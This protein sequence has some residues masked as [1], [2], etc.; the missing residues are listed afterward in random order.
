[1]I[2]LFA[3]G[4]VQSQLREKA[5]LAEQSREE[6]EATRRKVTQDTRAAFLNVSNGAA[7]VKAREETLKSVKS[8]LEATRLGREVG[9]RTSLDIL[10]AERAYQDARRNL[11]QAR[12]DY[13]KARLRLAAQVGE[14]NPEVLADINRLLQGKRS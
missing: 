1:M 11:A 7:Q 12:Y 8:Q 3:G 5:A 14:L 4:G 10:N 13:L 2:P 6:L 9:V